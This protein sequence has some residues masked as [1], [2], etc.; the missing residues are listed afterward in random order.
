MGE[1]GI[2]LANNYQEYPKFIDY[3]TYLNY[4]EPKFTAESKLEEIIFEFSNQ[5]GGY[6]TYLYLQL[7]NPDNKIIFHSRSQKEYNKSDV[8]MEWIS[9][10][11]SSGLPEM[12]TKF[13]NKSLKF[14]HSHAK[15]I[16]ST[17]LW[18]YEFDKETNTK[19]STAFDR[20][21]PRINHGL[22]D[23]MNDLPH[24]A[25]SHKQFLRELDKRSKK[26]ETCNHKWSKPIISR[27]GL[28]LRTC[29]KCELTEPVKNSG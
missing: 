3:T 11:I 19:L 6:I 26:Q 20:L 18:V 9:N 23:I 12:F 15:I 28:H 4:F 7:M 16:K 10:A 2:V 22:E 1:K 24:A 14:L 17:P 29:S 13:R 27:H 21:Y 5:V 25:S 8:I